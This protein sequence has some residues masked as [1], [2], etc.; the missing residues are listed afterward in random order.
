MDPNGAEDSVNKLGAASGVSTRE[1]SK[2]TLFVFDF[3]HTLVDNN[4]DTFVMSL[5]PEFNLSEATSEFSG[6]WTML[7]NEVMRL[8]CE[9]GVSV[10]EVSDHMRQLR[11]FKEA[12]KALKAVGNSETSD[13]II[14]SDSNSLFIDVIL[15]E[16]G[17]KHMVQSIITNSVEYRN[18]RVCISHYHSH[19]CPICKGSPNLC[20]GE[21]LSSYLECSEVPYKKVVYVGDGRNDMCPCL[22]LK[23]GDVVLCRKGYALSRLVEARK[24]GSRG[25]G[26]FREHNGASEGA[27]CETG[28]SLEADVFVIDFVEQLGEFIITK[29]LA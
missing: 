8:I 13:A 27:E 2:M 1:A 25:R 29:I 24:R 15:T 9:R 16:A 18:G 17:V 10:G 3:D 5:C 28:N 22:R 21:A 12:V 14:L 6:N 26:E 19:T 23:G 7:M 4:T 20:K 11:L